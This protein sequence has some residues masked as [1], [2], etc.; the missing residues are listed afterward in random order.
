MHFLKKLLF[1]FTIILLEQCSGFTYV[2]ANTEMLG[3][4][5]QEFSFSHLFTHNDSSKLAK[6]Y[7]H[8]QHK[9]LRDKK[10]T[11][12]TLSSDN[13]NES[14]ETYLPDS[15]FTMDY[16]VFGWYPYWEKSL[17][18]HINY[19]LLTTIAYFSY[20]IDPQNGSASSIH[21]WKTTSFID[22]A[23]AHN[24][25]VLLTITN[26][27]KNNNKQFLTNDNAITHLISEIITLLK[28]RSGN[29][30]C[31]DFEGIGKAQK[32]DFS[33][34]IKRLNQT[35]KKENK[36]YLTYIT[37]PAVDWNKSF[38]TEALIPEVD[39]FV[40]MGYG[41]YGATSTVAGPISP[42]NSGEIWYPY[43]LTT[44]VNYYLSKKIPSKRIILALPYYGNIWQTKTNTKGA[45]VSQFIGHRTLDYIGNKITAPLQYD[46]VSESVWCNYNVKS[47]TPAYR[48]CWFENDT[49]L[50]EK[51]KF[52]KSKKLS[53]MGIW[54][55]GY[56]QESNNMWNTIATNFESSTNSHTNGTASSATDTLAVDTLGNNSSLINNI[57]K[58]EALLQSITN[59]KTVL[60]YTL[61]FVVFFG[62]LGLVISMFQPNTRMIFFGSTAHIIF[63]VAT[64]LIFLIVLLHWTG[65]VTN[66]TILFILGFTSGG[67]A[68]FIS[69]KIIKKLDSHRP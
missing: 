65:F 33:Q 42:L 16:E 36:D 66:N 52:I 28:L 17:Y 21:D 53:G 39:Q 31:I 2:F 59:Y 63:Y 8:Q 50:S 9:K 37:V 18:K 13:S 40:I 55:L 43:N 7:I 30:V 60:L 49:T 58:V 24:T 69:N 56:N 4:T 38:D 26:F 15:T 20:E 68:M 64:I 27:G 44:T 3:S 6:Q 46:T 62:S 61:S 19:S 5:K 23:H 12:F 47:E 54:A 48:Q 41:Y 32:D 29:G 51:L 57:L 1:L 10:N 45:K 22:S 25:N 67:T 34:F 11:P 14:I 35:L